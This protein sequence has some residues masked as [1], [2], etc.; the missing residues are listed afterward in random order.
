[1][2][3]ANHQVTKS[4]DGQVMGA[5]SVATAR[6]IALAVLETVE[7]E[8]VFADVCLDQEF[9]RN[10]MDQRERGL[11]WQIVYGVLRRR[12][13]IDWR[14]AHVS[15][16]PIGLLPTTV[17]NALRIAAYQVLYLD[18]IPASA[19]VN[20]SVN[21]IKQRRGTASRDWSGFVNGV[22]R[23]LIRLPAPSYPDVE[24]DPTEALAVQYSCPAWLVARWVV[25]FGRKNAEALCR[26]TLEDPPITLRVNLLKSTRDDLQTVL[27]KAGYRVRP[28]PF[29]PVGL[30][31]EERVPVTELPLFAEGAFYIEDEAAQLV[32]LLLDAQPGE[33][34][35]DACA[36]P[37]GKTTHLAALMDNRGEI[38]AMDRSRPRLQ[39]IEENCRRLGVQIVTPVLGDAMKGFSGTFDRILVDAPCSGL[40]VLRRHPE[41]KWQKSAS[42]LPRHHHRQVEILDRMCTL[43]RPGGVLLYS[44]CSAEPEETEQVVERFCVQHKDFQRETVTPWMPAHAH[45]LL[46][47]QGDLS[48]ITMLSSQP[49]PASCHHMD[50]FFAV[51]FRKVRT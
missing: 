24:K 44:T 27:D 22:L 17:L 50:G 43:L 11:A 8:D 31:I 25:R 1:M 33:R 13:T 45:G 28:T 30:T 18:R 5:H 7:R 38:V 35:L 39:L 21:L 51:R 23:N 15:N 37:G 9:A 34:I 16:R 42:L 47:A 32:P 6:S 49:D 41:G 3:S 26:S 36:A 19:A 10:P 14:L 29:S 46:T 40:G 48:T 12:A 2:K 4:I 20:E